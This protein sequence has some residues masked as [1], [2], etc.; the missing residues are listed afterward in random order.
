MK[1]HVLHSYVD[2][3]VV[4]TFL[5]KREFIVQFKVACSELRMILQF[6]G[7]NSV[8]LGT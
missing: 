1:V 5:I 7:Q 3:F 8:L 4:H 2:V 6:C